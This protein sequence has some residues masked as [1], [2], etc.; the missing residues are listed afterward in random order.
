MPSNVLINNYKAFGA[1]K[2]GD[3][4]DTFA[5]T[6]IT[7]N[8]SFIRSHDDSVAIYNA[9]ANGGRIWYGDTKNITVTNSILMPDFARP[10][11]M[12]THGFTWAPGGGHTIEDLTFSNLDLWIH[13]GGQRIQFISADGNLIQNV[14]FNDIRIDD[15]SRRPIFSYERSED[16][17]MA[18]GVELTMFI[19]RISPIPAVVQAVI[20]LKATIPPVGFKI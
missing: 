3:G 19:S 6:N 2:W 4:I 16:G 13:N 10:I 12:G 18:L 8:D 1:N 14:N 5:A 7:I 15:T 9:R 11:N 20:R 17:I